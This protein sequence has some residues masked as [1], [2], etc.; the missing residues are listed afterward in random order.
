MSV[1]AEAAPHRLLTLPAGEVTLSLRDVQIV[2]V[3]IAF[4]TR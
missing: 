2:D 1:G 3:S 4:Y